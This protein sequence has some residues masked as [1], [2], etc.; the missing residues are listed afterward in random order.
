[1][2][3]MVEPWLT[4]IGV[5]EDGRAGLSTAS[6]DALHRAEVVFGAP[7]HLAL[8][9]VQGQAWPVPFDIAP[10][11]ALRG[12]RVVMLASGDPFWFGA[13]GSIAAH[14]APGEW[15][16]HPAPS[17]FALAA[18][19]LG[20]RLEEVICMGLHAAPFAR[21]RP[22]LGRGTHAICLLRDGGAVAGLASY[23]CEIGFGASAITVLERLGGPHARLRQTRAEDMNLTGIM[24]PVAVAIAAQ[25][26]GLPDASGLPDDLFDHDGQ[27]T[28]R[29]VRA[30]TLSA[31]APRKGEVLLDIGAGSGSVGI[32]WLL[33]GGGHCHAVEADPTRAA[34]AQRNVAHFGL[35]HRYQLHPLR[36]PHGLDGLPQPDAVFIGGGATDALLTCL[37]DL[38]VPG[39]R[40]VVNAVTLETEA[41]LLDWSARHGGALLKIELSE[42]GPL[43]TKRGWQAARPILHWSVTR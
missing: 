19:Q 35:E 37:W 15:V 34:R 21:L 30:L 36:A 22:V 27:I 40:L 20:W 3:D 12:Q 31:L 28:K 1:M 9:R 39:T 18:N 25:G 2:R 7:R 32:A 41:L 33:A 14:L 16:S 17:T 43:G 13:G 26:A 4:I 23:L 8:L 6:L 5:N 11:L 10:V 38:I 29:P 24:A 42:A